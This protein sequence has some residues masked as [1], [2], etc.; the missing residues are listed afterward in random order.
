MR[1]A[2]AVV[3]LACSAATIRPA[4]ADHGPSV[5]GAEP[6]VINSEGP[7]AACGGAFQAPCAA[8]GECAEGLNVSAFFS[9]KCIPEEFLPAAAAAM[10][11]L[12]GNIDPAG[13]SAQ[14]HLDPEGSVPGPPLPERTIPCAAASSPS[15]PSQPERTA[16]SAPPQQE[17]TATPQASQPPR[18]PQRDPPAAAKPQKPERAAPG[19]GP[20]VPGGMH[21]RK[22]RK[23]RQPSAFNPEG[24]V[25]IPAPAAPDPAPKAR[26]APSPPTPQPAAAAD[27]S[28]A[29]E[30]P[31]AA[32][33]PGATPLSASVPVT[34][35]NERG[36][37]NGS[38]AKFGGCGTPG[39]PCCVAV[40]DFL[41]SGYCYGAITCDT[42]SAFPTCVRQGDTCGG[43]GVGG[44]CVSPF[45]FAA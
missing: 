45:P 35:A 29:Q 30:P 2:V 23:E 10:E 25:L 17:R 32:P 9:G 39:Q 28:A 15:T 12:K 36:D 43:I 38:Q 20:T 7:P 5:A 14:P 8:T 31:P 44:T 16:A 40:L 33:R 11:G 42:D 41:T 34:R 18:Q 37:G 22:P 19:S 13:A 24:Y 4:I 21:A 6:W 1:A 3:L 26:A 27:A